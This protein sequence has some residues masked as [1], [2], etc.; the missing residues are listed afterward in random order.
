VVGASMGAAV[1][2]ELALGSS[3]AAVQRLVLLTLAIEA[4]ARLEAVLRSWLEFDAPAKRRAHSLA[5]AVVPERRC[6]RRCAEARGRSTG[7]TRDGGPDSAAD[8]VEQM[9]AEPDRRETDLL[10]RARHRQVLR[11]A[12]VALDLRKLNAELHPRFF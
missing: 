5:A 12:H 10:G 6:S 3:R 11:P 7:A 2:I 4:D 1:A 8:A 9:V